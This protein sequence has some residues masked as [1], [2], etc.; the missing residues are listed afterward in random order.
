M[1]TPKKRFKEN[2][3]KLEKLV[4]GIEEK[5]RTKNRKIS[6]FKLF[7][8]FLLTWFLSTSFLFI[9]SALGYDLKMSYGESMLPLLDGPCLHIVREQG[10]YNVGD[11]VI[12]SINPKMKIIHRIVDVCDGGF[13]LK[14]DNNDHG[15]GCIPLDYILFKSVF[16]ICW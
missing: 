10:S 6:L 3:A 2:L 15:D 4:N 5:L 11:I 14:G 8:C 9:L 12:F 13:M 16:H 1:K 7:F